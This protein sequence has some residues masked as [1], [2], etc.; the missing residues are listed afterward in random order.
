V[1]RLV[2]RL[3]MSVQEPELGRQVVP[4]WEPQRQVARPLEPEWKF[5]GDMT[6][7]ICNVCIRRGIRSRVSEVRRYKLSS[8]RLL[9]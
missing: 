6:M 4:L 1:R 3:A 8:R 2:L 7:P 9:Q 5:K